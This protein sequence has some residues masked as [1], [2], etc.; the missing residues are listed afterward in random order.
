MLDT[1]F[2]PLGRLE[3]LHSL[4]MGDVPEPVVAHDPEDGGL[5]CATP[6]VAAELKIVLQGAMAA[7][8]AVDDAYVIEARLEKGG[9]GFMVGQAGSVDEGTA[10][11]GE[12]CTGR[13]I[14]GRHCTPAVRPD[15][16]HDIAPVGHLYAG[17][18]R[19]GPAQHRV[20]SEYFARPARHAHDW[21][22]IFKVRS[23]NPP[24]AKLTGTPAEDKGTDPHESAVDRLAQRSSEGGCLATR[25][26]C[27]LAAGKVPV[28]KQS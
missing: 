24:A 8:T 5:N 14:G 11:D 16:L 25:K 18:G 7:D 13:P 3:L 4:R 1:Q 19:Q 9:A 2:V 22:S 28:G 17:I 23:A 27:Y 12:G 15:G 6:Q 26:P 10:I 21:W 20:R